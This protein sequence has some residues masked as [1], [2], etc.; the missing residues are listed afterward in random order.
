[1]VPQG[2]LILVTGAAGFIGSHLCEALIMRGYRVRGADRIALKDAP[3][4]AT[5]KD[6]QFE[7]AQG[8]AS[9]PAVARKA[10]T[11]AAAILHHAAMASVPQSIADPAAAHRDTATTTLHLLAAARETGVK[12]FVLA[13][14]AAVYGDALKLPVREDIQL[15]PKSP[16]A[17]AKIASEAYVSAFSRLGVEGISLRYFNVFGPRQSPQSSYAGVVTQFVH[18]ILKGE[19]LVIFGDGEQTRDFIDV[20]DVVRAN[21]LALEAPSLGG[22]AVNIATGKA[23][24]IAELVEVLGEICGKQPKVSKKPARAG[25]IKASCADVSLAKRLLGF[26]PGADLKAGLRRA[27]EWL[28][29]AK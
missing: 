21:L 7:F 3:N 4:L 23:I 13:S 15:A 12:R 1:M 14:S 5:L 2:S 27:V 19:E 17:A 29:S 26:V 28:R 10:A 18:R 8:D 6:K 22:A 20:A 24:S 11:G 16:Y 25:D 9:D